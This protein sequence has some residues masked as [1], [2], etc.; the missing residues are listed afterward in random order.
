MEGK[1]LDPHYHIPLVRVFF[2][3]K[4][5]QIILSYLIKMGFS[6]HILEFFKTIFISLN[7]VG[8]CIDVMSN[9]NN[10][11]VLKYFIFNS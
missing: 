8:Q 2:K 3:A 4:K 7:L 10:K 5:R 11:I 1:H 9:Y 6:F